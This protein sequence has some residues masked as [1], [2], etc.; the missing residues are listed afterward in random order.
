[1]SMQGH[2]WQVSSQ[3][4]CSHV[5]LQGVTLPADVKTYVQNDDLLL[6]RIS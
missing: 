4:H 3:G 1:M 2:V 5:Q 6:Q